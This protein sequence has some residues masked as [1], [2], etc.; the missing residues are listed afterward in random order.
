MPASTSASSATGG[1]REASLAGLALRARLP[2]AAAVAGAAHEEHARSC[3]SSYDDTAA[4]DALRALEQPD[5]PRGGR[6]DER[7]GAW[8]RASRCSTSCAAA[9]ASCSSPTS[10]PTA[11]RSARWWPCTRSSGAWARTSLMFLA[12]DDFPLPYEYR[13]FELDGLVTRRRPTSPTAHDRLP[14]LRQHRPQPGRAVERRAARPQ[15]R[16]PP[17][18]HALRQRQPR[19]PRRLVHGRDRVGPACAR[20]AWTPTREIAEALYVGLVTDT[21]HFMYENTGRRRT[22]WRPT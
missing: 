17:R 20:S 10:T 12:A 18:Q 2:A 16:P 21:G 6:R 19:R 22:S 1:A 8:A 11:T 3:S 14:G 4:A 5:R 15:P 13:F 7:S 9:S